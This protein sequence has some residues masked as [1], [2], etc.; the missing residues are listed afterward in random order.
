[1]TNA[2]EP[3]KNHT[4]LNW[5]TVILII[6]TGGGNWLATSQNSSQRQYEQER[7]YQQIHELHAG[8]DDEL[9]RIAAILKNQETLLLNQERGLEELKKGQAPGP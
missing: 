1:M 8:L 7:A 6:V 4:A 9:K 5:P 3:P 2:E